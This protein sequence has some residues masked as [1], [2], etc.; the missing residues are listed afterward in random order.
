MKMI[1]FLDLKRENATCLT[2]LQDAM[3][4]VTESGWYLHGEEKALFEEQFAT[5]CG[6]KYAIGVA[7]GLDALRLILLAY[8]E[9][10]RLHDGDEVILP[11]NTFIATAL[12]VSACNLTPVFADCDIKTYN[13]D[14]ISVQNKLTARTRAIIAVHLYGQTA[15]MNALKSISENNKL[16]LIEDAAQAHGATYH[17]KKAGSLADAAAFSFYPSKNL[18]ALA[19]AGAVTTDNDELNEAIRSLCNYGSSKKYVYQHKGIN[20][21]MSELQAA[22][23]NV[24]LKQLDTNNIKRNQ[25]AQ[26]YSQHIHNSHIIKPTICNEGEHVFHLYVIRCQNRDSLQAYLTKSGIQTQIHYPIP[27]H[28]QEAYKEYSKLSLP[29]SEQLQNEILSLPLY[30]T[31][32][33]DEINYII[34]SLNNWRI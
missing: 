3:C 10:G 18:G 21:R 13:I 2:E 32:K 1:P 19:D 11:A 24:K 12:A 33:E 28:K 15:D 29:I 17:Q 7:N 26:N 22:V 14:P 23:L 16:I 31:L 4:R 30:P 6:V 5:F 20:S 25:L 34:E 27:I 8:K 9:I